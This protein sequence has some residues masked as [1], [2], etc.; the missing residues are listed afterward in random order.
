MEDS[1]I[2]LRSVQD[3]GDMESYGNE[4]ESRRRAALVSTPKSKGRFERKAV[5]WWEDKCKEAIKNRNRAFRILQRTPN[6]QHRIE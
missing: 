4:I 3:E 2:D 5:P 1:D 6:Y